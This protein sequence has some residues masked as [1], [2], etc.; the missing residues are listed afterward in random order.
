MQGHGAPCRLIDGEEV[1]PAMTT[2]PRQQRDAESPELA[3]LQARRLVNWRQTEATRLPDSAAAV[4]LIE[5]VGVAT[6]YPVTPELPNLYHA[7]VGDPT[8]PTDSQWDSPSGHVYAWRWELGGREAAFY[9]VLARRRPTLIAWSMLPALLRLCGELRTPDELYDAG[10][11]SNEA[12]RVAAALESAGGTLTTGQLRKEAGFPTGKPQRAAY[13]KAVDE[14]DSRLLL[15]KVFSPRHEDGGDEAGTETGR[16]A[17]GTETGGEAAGTETGGEAAMGHALVR[18][19]Y[20]ERV[21]AAEALTREEALDRFLHTYL[22]AAVYAVP[23]VL[24]RALRLAD[25]EVRTG[26]R[27]LEQEGVAEPLLSGDDKGK[28]APW[29]RYPDHGSE[30]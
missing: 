30:E 2:T 29:Y 27:R 1:Y 15:A 13:L 6:L 19:R 8:R 22:R 21:A 14:L 5:R 16:E 17:A 10:A 24:A 28:K 3:A 25:D 18:L 11:L 7:Y 26:L 20:P 9:S 4:E 23:P 12:Y